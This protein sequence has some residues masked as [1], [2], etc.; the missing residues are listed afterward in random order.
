MHDA[1][2]V[3]YPDLVQTMRSWG[4]RCCGCAA[5]RNATINKQCGRASAGSRCRTEVG[6]QEKIGCHQTLVDA[7]QRHRLRLSAC[8]L[9]PTR[10]LLR[11]RPF[12]AYPIRARL[13]SDVTAIDG[14]IRPRHKRC[15]SRAK[16]N[17][18]LGHLLRVSNA[19]DRMKRVHHFARTRP[20]LAG[21]SN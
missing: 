2:M 5:A 6:L 10:A 12:E 14:D 9:W 1:C 18:E 4:F 20:P 8:P 19:T 16:P 13:L 11:P 21:L 3:R 7:C 15:A 17:D